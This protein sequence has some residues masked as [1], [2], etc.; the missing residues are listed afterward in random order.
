MT[1]NSV[2]RTPDER[3]R[4]ALVLQAIGEA[5]DTDG[6]ADPMTVRMFTPDTLSG[7]P[8]HSLNIQL[9]DNSADRLA[10]WASSFDLDPTVRIGGLNE[11]GGGGHFRAHEVVGSWEGWRINVETY[12]DEPATAEGGAE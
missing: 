3:A 4:P 2:S 1:T 5:I 10:A 9:P 7:Y 11:K 8:Y 6:L 12:V